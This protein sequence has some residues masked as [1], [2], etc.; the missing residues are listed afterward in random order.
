MWRGLLLLHL[1]TTVFSGPSFEDVALQ[2]H[3]SKII[4]SLKGTGREKT[5][6]MKTFGNIIWHFPFFGFAM[7]LITAIG[8]LIWCLTVIGIPIGLGLFQLSL[9][10][11]APFT[12]RMVSQ[13]DLVLLTGEEQATAVKWWFTVIRILLF[14]FGCLAAFAS[15]LHIGIQFIS[16]IGIPCAMAEA[17]ALST[18]FNPINKK[19]VPL[20]IAEEIDRRKNEIM[21]N[22]YKEQETHMSS[23]A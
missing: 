3:A 18:I 11:L 13:Q 20:A 4:N 16:I 2:F 15:A 10:Y 8:G 1:Y 22:K 23:I 7:S 14:P 5:S 12:K 9:F 6:N 17:K 19:C 21:L